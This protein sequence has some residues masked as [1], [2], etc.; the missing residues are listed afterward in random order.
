M[1]LS[2]L[3]AAAAA[4]LLL[5]PA[6]SAQD[7]PARS[8][9]EA[10]VSPNAGVMQTIGTT[11]LEIH[12]GRPSVNGREIFGGLEPY[13]QVWR[14]GAN[15]ATVFSVSSDVMVE[16]EILPAGVYGLF[17]IPGE[18]EWTIIFNT[19]AEQWG[20]YNYDASQDV[21]RVT[22]APVS[23]ATPQEQFLISFESVSA[24]GAVMVLAW[25][26]VRV[27][28]SLSTGG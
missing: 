20:A 1:K 6:A 13:G 11:D 18:T 14:T 10:R 4:L 2:F 23:S 8:N 7:V 27:P 24:G 22:A 9:D 5:V 26:D 16:G 28:V 3:F 15:E 17:T 19:V 12:Y 21:L 25:D